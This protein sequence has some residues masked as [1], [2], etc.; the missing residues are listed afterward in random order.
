MVSS[1]INVILLSYSFLVL[2]DVVEAD[3]GYKILQQQR[4][5][6]SKCGTVYG[7]AVDWTCE[8]VVT[9]GQVKYT[10]LNRVHISIQGLVV[11]CRRPPK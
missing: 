4:Q 9:V 11:G 1:M 8:T 3:N 10:F 5:K 6:A 2:R 7:M